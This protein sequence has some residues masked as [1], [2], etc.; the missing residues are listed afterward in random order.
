[1]IQSYFL[2]ANSATGFQSCYHSFCTEEQDFLYVIKGG[3][4]SGKSTFMKKIGAA[5]ERRGL[6]V[7]YVRCSGDPD[8][9]DGVYMPTLHLGYVDGT[10]PHVIEPKY[11]GIS[12]CYLDFSKFFDVAGLQSVASEIRELNKE[13]KSCYQAAYTCLAAHR[14][15]SAGIPD[16]KTRFR[17]AITCQGLVTLPAPSAPKLVSESDLIA[18]SECEN[19]VRYL[20]PLFPDRIVG[21]Y[22]ISNDT[23]WESPL[24]LP[25][26]SDAVE[27]L[28]EAKRLH[29]NLESLY[30]P[31]VD[32]SG[33]NNLLS[34]HK[35][36]LSDCAK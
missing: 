31:F 20:H 8:S 17:H 6:D 9:L 25:D 29:D 24:N 11:P 35:K 16:G 34:T 23:Y 13:Y 4:G 18:L 1:M 15:K 30:R 32:F 36:A 3:P 28:L 19:G 22:D 26:C 10:A 27:F 12:G 2:G 7:H 5:A 33:I 21:V 14:A